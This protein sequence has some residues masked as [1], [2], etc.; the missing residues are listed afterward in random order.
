[1]NNRHIHIQHIAELNSR[2]YVVVEACV[3]PGG[4]SGGIMH[5]SECTLNGALS[6]EVRNENEVPVEAWPI[7]TWFK[8]PF[9][10]K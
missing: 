3:S 4:L 5:S 10:I 2:C 7:L 1:M 9:K 8:Q 6:N